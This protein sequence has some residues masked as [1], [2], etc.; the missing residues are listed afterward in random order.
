MNTCEKKT[1]TKVLTK[2]I[3][4]NGLFNTKRGNI[5]SKFELNPLSSLSS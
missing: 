4:L 2:T 3:Q 1:R 5:P